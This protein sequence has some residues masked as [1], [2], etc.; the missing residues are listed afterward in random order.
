M[1]KRVSDIDLSPEAGYV[2][3]GI[4]PVVT[5]LEG[6]KFYAFG[7]SKYNSYIFDIGG[8]IEKNE[9]PIQ[10]AVREYHEESYGVFGEISVDDILDQDYEVIDGLECPQPIPS[11]DILYPVD[12]DM[13]KSVKEF[14]KIRKTQNNPELSQVIW[15]SDTDIKNI[16]KYHQTLKFQDFR[17]F[18]TYIMLKDP[19]TQIVLRELI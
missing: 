1:L 11:L 13:L 10:A 3:A 2:R 7:L 19:L 12:I 8:H 17:P 15:L 14:N 9:D 6:R 4:I 16:Y 5:N 18:M